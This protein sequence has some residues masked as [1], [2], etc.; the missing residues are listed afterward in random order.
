MA[1][2]RVPSFLVKL[3]KDKKIE[4]MQHYKIWKTGIVAELLVQ[5]LNDELDRLVKED[6]KDSLL[7]WFQTRWSQAKRLGRREQLR[8]LIKDLS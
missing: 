2:V 4:A 8:Q 6:E 5:H 1:Q 7:S 3:E